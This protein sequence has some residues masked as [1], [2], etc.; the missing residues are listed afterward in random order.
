MLGFPGAGKTT[1]A[2]ELAQRYGFVLLTADVI[3]IAVIQHPQWTPAEHRMFFGMLNTLS[4]QLLAAGHSVIYD[5][6]HNQLSTREQKYTEA[7]DAGANVAVLHIVTDKNTQQSRTDTRTA[8]GATEVIPADKLKSTPAEIFSKLS[9]QFEAP[10]EREPVITVNGALPAD[11][12]IA[13]IAKGLDYLGFHLPKKR[14]R[15]AT[16]YMMLGLPGSGKTTTATK[17]AQLTGAIHLSSDAFRLAIH[18]KPTFSEA[19]HAV[20]YAS[21]DY[22]TELL[23]AHGIDVIYDANLN[24]KSHRTDKYEICAKTGARCRL[25]WVQTSHELAQSRRVAD[26]HHLLRPPYESPEAMFARIAAIFETPD[27][28]LEPYTVLDGTKITTNYLQKN[29]GL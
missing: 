9:A 3:R 11:L 6:N 13:D 12:Q 14:V 19:E 1:C 16:L 10:S 2:R 8:M 5:A 15:R 7:A 25:L 17:L 24:R 29:L 20:L 4:T 23:L 27:T 22:A 28:T 21:L 18:P 26:S